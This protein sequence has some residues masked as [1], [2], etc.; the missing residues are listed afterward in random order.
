M[1]RNSVKYRSIPARIETTSRRLRADERGVAGLVTAIAATVLLGFCGLA[2]DVIMWQ[3][4]QRG[5][6]GA[7]DQAALGAATAYRNAGETTALGDSQTAKNGAYATAIQSGYPAASVTVAAYNN[8]GTCINDG[9][10]QVTIT[11]QQQQRF[12][13]AIFMTQDFS[14][15]A[16]AVGTCSGC[17]NGSFTVSSTGGDACVMSLDTSGAGVITASGT[18][19]LSLNHCNLYNN[20]P[21]TN[22]TIMNGGAVIEG[23]SATNACGSKAFL[24]QPDV[25]AG[26]I[27]IPNRDQ[28]G[29]GA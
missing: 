10:L 13:T 28:C 27:D 22:A 25:P 14:E 17:G 24:A 26:N 7:A 3:V 23:C 6:Q 21:N 4:N 29:A 19:V 20:S 15:S 12:F 18:P 5:L 16:S 8:A 9:C 2:I 11:Q 1:W